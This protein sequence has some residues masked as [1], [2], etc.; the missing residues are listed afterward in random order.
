MSSAHV[1]VSG[2]S[3]KRSDGTEPDDVGSE[4]DF[5]DPSVRQRRREMWLIRSGRIALLA[6]VIMGWQLVSGSLISSF[7]ISSPL[8]IV[9]ALV[10][11]E[12]EGQLWPAVTTTLEETF[13]GFAVGA[14]PAIVLGVLLGL[15]SVV[16]RILD[17]FFTA[18]NSIPRIALIPLMILWLGIGFETKVLFAA[19][20]VFFPVFLT[21]IAGVRDVDQHLVETLRVLGASRREILRKVTVPASLVWVFSG[22]RI[23]VPFALLGA[24]VA[25]MFAGGDG[26][27]FLLSSSSNYFDT[28]GAFA[29]LLVITVLG[30]IIT[31]ALDMAQ[32]RILRWQ[33]AGR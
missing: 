21:T 30:L 4:L 25:E 31:G 15:N 28:A 24:V 18:L 17:P 9:E 2:R 26:L 11:F 22:L 6:L 33:V 13:L 27:G 12:R 20:L 23:S 32:R 8:E 19:L 3:P 5:I 16:A 29:A 14:V 10:E 7:W 1:E